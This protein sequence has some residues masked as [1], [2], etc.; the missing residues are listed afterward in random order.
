[1]RNLNEYQFGEWRPEIYEEEATYGHP[2]MLYELYRRGDHES[3]E[4][5]LTTEKTGKWGWQW[6]N[7]ARRG[8]IGGRYAMGEPEWTLSSG[9][10]SRR[11]AWESAMDYMLDETGGDPKNFGSSGAETSLDDE[12]VEKWEKFHK[13]LG[14]EIKYDFD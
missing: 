11:A 1:M 2:E 9:H 13:G 7:P 3:A 4:E 10:P 14:H 6:V 5:S 8:V 12:D